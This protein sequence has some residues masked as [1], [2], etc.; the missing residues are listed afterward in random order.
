MK[1]KVLILGLTLV[2]LSFSQLLA[3]PVPVKPG[4]ALGYAEGVYAEFAKGADDAILFEVATL[5]K[6][7]LADI[8]GIPFGELIEVPAHRV[9]SSHHGLQITGA[10]FVTPL[11]KAYG[12]HD[13]GFTVAGFE[14]VGYPISLGVY[15]KLQVGVAI[16][17]TIQ[18]HQ[19]L[20]FSWPSL[21][22]SVILDP[23]VIFLES[24]V[25]NRMR[26]AGEGWSPK[27]LLS[28]TIQG[29]GLQ[30]KASCQL[31]GYPGYVGISYTWDPYTWRSWNVFGMTLVEEF[32]AGQQAAV[33]CVANGGCYGCRAMPYGYSYAS[34]CNSYLGWTCDCDHASGW[35]TNSCE[36][37]GKFIAETKCADRWA[38]KAS[39]NGS[40]SGQGSI[41]VTIDW[42]MS[43]GVHSNG[44]H[45]IQSCANY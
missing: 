6:G 1:S 24:S 32:L 5:S 26:L 17:E 34:S 37:Q 36:D 45:I 13:L 12:G 3:A 44:G 20:E 10:T 33:Q 40:V 35:G 11:D 29:E 25:R 16:G 30:R 31:V 18:E 28:R 4:T 23:V 8:E 39:A 41:G 19:A 38:I 27:V 9:E 22:H 21:G 14:A 43:G 15:R 42:S 2:A 7:K